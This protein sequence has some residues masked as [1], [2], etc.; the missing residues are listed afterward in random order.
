[1]RVC[2][3]ACV[4]GCVCECVCVDECGLLPTINQARLTNKNCSSPDGS[5]ALRYTPPV[6]SEACCRNPESPHNTQESIGT[7]CSGEVH[8]RE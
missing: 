2:V 3:C 5:G 8:S 1:M 6:I 7:F 4:C